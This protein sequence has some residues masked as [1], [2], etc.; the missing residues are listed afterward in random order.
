METL[1]ISASSYSNTAPL[2]WSF[3]YGQNHGRAELIL[4]TAPARSAELLRTGRVDA[5]LVPVIASQFIDDVKI[6]PGVCVGARERVR[7]VCIISRG[8]GLEEI[9]SISLD[10]SS[11]TSAALTKIIFREF[12]GSEP[13]WTDAMPDPKAMLA[14]SDAALLIG[15]PALAISETGRLADGTTVRIFDLAA[16]WRKFTGLGFIFAMWMTRKDQIEI[17]FASARNEGISHIEEIISNYLPDI[18]ISRNEMRLYL[19]ENI[20][21]E[22]DEEMLCGMQL[23]LDLAAK[24]NLL[25]APVRLQML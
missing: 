8:K 20:I 1:R 4:D 9:R 2:I 3:I 13:D 25:H 21:Y 14:E 6:I 5:A 24:H 18:P 15:D 17:D 22:P 19:T 16:I 10:T 12:I 11:R 7:S 23:Y